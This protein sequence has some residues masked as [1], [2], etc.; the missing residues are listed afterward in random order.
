MLTTATMSETITMRFAKIQTIPTHQFVVPICP[1]SLCISVIG[2][3]INVEKSA[4]D[5]HVPNSAI[6]RLKNAPFPP[7]SIGSEPSTS[8]FPQL[9]I[10]N[11]SGIGVMTYTMNVNIGHQQFEKAQ[12]MNSIMSATPKPTPTHVIA[13]EGGR[14]RGG[15]GKGGDG[16]GGEMGWEAAWNVRVS[17]C[18]CACVRACVQHERH[19][20]IMNDVCVS[21]LT[22][23]CL[24]ERVFS[25]HAK[26]LKA[27]R[28]Q[29]A[30]RFFDGLHPNRFVHSTRLSSHQNL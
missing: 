11:E 2:K 13:A 26:L 29:T 9:A 10:M 5:K 20:F 21:Q 6:I 12:I 23:G 14:R 18:T 27:A 19:L 28:K 1:T 17:A 15:G 7:L 22:N 4:P 25:A 24:D 3:P 30:I 8:R 16:E